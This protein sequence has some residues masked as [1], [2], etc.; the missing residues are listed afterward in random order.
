MHKERCSTLNKELIQL[1]R[2]ANSTCV[3]VTNDDFDNIKPKVVMKADIA[4]KFLFSSNPPIFSDG[5][6]KTCKK[7]K[8]AYL[9]ITN[10]DALP[11]EE[12]NKYVGLV[13]DREM[14][15]YYLPNN[16]IIVFTVKSKESLKNISKELYHFA[17]VA[18]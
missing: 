14:K 11:A 6:N 9:V 16:C 8:L 3:I 17:V 10:I 2:N 4:D 12:Q 7:S 13:K 15:G 18:F 1:Q 5:I